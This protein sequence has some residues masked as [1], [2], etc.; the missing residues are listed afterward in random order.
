[1][2]IQMYKRMCVHVCIYTCA[3][4][5]A[6]MYLDVYIYK[7]ISMHYME[8]ETLQSPGPLIEGGQAWFKSD[9]FSSCRWWA[10][11]YSSLVMA[12]IIRTTTLNLPYITPNPF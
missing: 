2:Y 10:R 9:R 7:Y 8:H 3:R 4:V 5:D 1:M 11:R 12:H 6:H